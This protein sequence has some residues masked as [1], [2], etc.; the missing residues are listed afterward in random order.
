M[1]VQGALVGKPHEP[2]IREQWYYNNGH[3]EVVTSIYF[4]KIK[5]KYLQN[6]LGLNPSQQTILSSSVLCPAN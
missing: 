4:V 1:T 6:P 5:K 2:N 3:Q